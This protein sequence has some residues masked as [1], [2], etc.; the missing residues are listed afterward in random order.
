MQAKLIKTEADHEAAL[1]RIDAIFDAT[2][3]TPAGDELEL[4]ITLVE[5]YEKKAFPIGLP[6][7]VDA[8]KFRMEQQGLKAKDLIPFLGSAPKV[9]EVISG[10]RS[11]S[12]TMIRNLVTGLG[13]PAEVLLQVQSARIPNVSQRNLRKRKRKTA[14]AAKL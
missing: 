13:I 7:P 12:L 1:T 6:S 3:G 10:K 14:A 9:S 5:L 8:I 4:L 2:P 11:L